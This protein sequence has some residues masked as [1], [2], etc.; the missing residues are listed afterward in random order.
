MTLKRNGA[1][2]QDQTG[3]NETL[4]LRV[5][6]A[7]A[8]DAG[9]DE[10]ESGEDEARIVSAFYGTDAAGNPIPVPISADGQSISLKTLPGV[11]TLTVNIVSPSGAQT[12]VQLTQNGATLSE[13][14]LDEHT[15]STA[16]QIEGI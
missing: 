3:T 12:T 13:A 8:L 11:N 1:A 14:I 7:V 15:A 5:V 10:T 6:Q 2:F 16:V 4:V 9:A